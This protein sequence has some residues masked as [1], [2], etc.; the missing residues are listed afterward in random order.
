MTGSS[1]PGNHWI[2]HVVS[3]SKTIDD[4]RS[5]ISRHTSRK[6]D[7]SPLRASGCCSRSPNRVDNPAS[8]QEANSYHRNAR[9]RHCKQDNLHSALYDARVLSSIHV[10]NL[11]TATK[12][13]C[14]IQATPLLEKGNSD[15]DAI[16]C[17]VLDEVM[18]ANF[19][20]CCVHTDLRMMD[21]QWEILAWYGSRLMSSIHARI[22]SKATKPSV[23]FSM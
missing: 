21:I 5:C 23:Y 12:H 4:Y 18:K 16:P 11:N 3:E 19:G 13:A 7:E 22:G 6:S 17:I 14:V 2:S 8:W 9:L 20:R 10:N 1:M 15:L